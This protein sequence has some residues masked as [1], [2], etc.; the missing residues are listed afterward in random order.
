MGRFAAADFGLQN[1]IHLVEVLVGEWIE[2]GNEK[3][4]FESPGPDVF[5]GLVH[6][7]TFDV[8]ADIHQTSL[9]I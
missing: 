7:K 5:F 2:I 4:Q 3:P 8:V 9:G 6:Q 1:L